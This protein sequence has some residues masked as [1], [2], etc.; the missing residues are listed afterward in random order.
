MEWLHSSF[1]WY[2]ILFILGILF[3]PTTSIL[4]KKFNLD[5][6]YS[7]SK[8][9]AIIVLSYTMFIFGIIKILPF[10]QVT[11]LI[12]LIIFAAI[13]FYIL[14]KYKPIQFDPKKLFYVFFQEIVFI[15]SFTT[16]IFVRGQEPSIHSLEKFMDFGFINSILRSSY[17]PPADIWYA[18]HS[19]NY[20]YF[21]HLSGALLIKL[22]Q[23]LPSIG[24]NLIL[25]TLF[26]LGI[27]QVFS[28]V[29]NMAQSTLEI[30][31]KTIS[32][33][34]IVILGL[35]GSFIVNLGGNLQ[36]IYLFSKGYPNDHP[37][38][39]WQIL[40]WFN[41]T[42][43][44]YPNATRFIPFTIHE[45]PSYSYV[46]ADLHGHVFDIPFVLLT[47]AILFTLF[48]KDHKKNN[49]VKEKISKFQINKLYI[50]ILFGFL[51]AVH[52][53]TNAFD[54]PIYMLLSFFCLLMV[55][56]FSIQLIV[57][58]V[59][60]IFSF[61]LFSYPF[62]HFFSPFVSGIGV[63]CSPDFLTQIGKIGPFLFVKGNC[64]ISPLW[65][66]GILWGFFWVNYV[67]FVI[68]QL[69]N[70]EKYDPILQQ[71]YNFILILFSFGTFLIIIPEFFYIK[72]IYPQH[73]R[74]NT[75][76][77]LGYQA[78]I[79]MGIASTMVFFH[80]KFLS[81]L[82]S[83]LLGGIFM[84]FFFFIFIYPFFSIP[85]YYGSMSKKINLDGST[86]LNEQYPEDKEI[87]D[88]LNTKV[89]NQPNILEAQGDSYTDFER[90]SAFT[91]LPTVAG[92][93]VH[94]WLWRGSSKI[95][96]NR[97][98]EVVSIYES[99]DI[100][101]TSRLIQKYNISYIVISRMERQKYTNINEEKFLKI[102]KLIFKSSNGFG[103]LYQ[104]N[105]Q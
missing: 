47:I 79:M 87:I 73:F 3:Y 37:V 104:V 102:G 69:T 93:W 30:M 39:F 70:K 59:I 105:N 103:A 80:I 6:G 50:P 95:I 54:G 4:L 41:P 83:L 74:A 44:W 14:I 48:I 62:S 13:N 24:Y 36:T 68:I 78:F 7:F 94:E 33:L 26:A 8:T 91:G 11:L 97:I 22:T 23:T 101:E 35:F 17:F 53:M 10:T 57:S 25:A 2:L 66:L 55:Y 99:S 45:F 71:I 16:W 9:I 46:V 72:D 75:M 86:W 58:M 32:E 98:P 1:Y 19:I 88:Y 42:K 96:S 61:V 90:I 64:Q 65:M 20:Y 43:Y 21:G 84:F 85:S 52:Y 81:K 5:N 27:T 15:F 31:K 82:K 100:D 12:L 28:L 60:I 56:N 76:F 40:S 63:N 92:W 49:V 51:T 29:C 18:N 89:P 67:I 38:P 34:K 77:K